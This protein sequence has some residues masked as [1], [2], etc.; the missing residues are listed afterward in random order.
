L[1]FSSSTICADGLRFLIFQHISSTFN[2]I[3]LSKTTSYEG[4]TF[5]S[6]YCSS[7]D[8][9]LK[10]L[11]EF[12]P[13]HVL[14]P[15]SSSFN[16]LKA[17]AYQCIYIPLHLASGANPIDVK[18]IAALQIRGHELLACIFRTPYISATPDLAF[19]CAIKI[20]LDVFI[21]LN[22]SQKV[23]HS[24]SS[25]LSAGTLSP[26]D[27][28]TFIQALVKSLSIAKD[29]IGS[30][31]DSNP[32][33]ISALPEI[34]ATLARTSTI[35]S[36]TLF[37]ELAG[38]LTQSC[39]Q[40]LVNTTDRIDKKHVS[41]CCKSFDKIL[42]ISS[43]SDVFGVRGCSL[44]LLKIVLHAC[45]QSGPS[46]AS[47]LSN[48]QTA[49]TGLHHVLLAE[50]ILIT[51]YKEG[52]ILAGVFCFHLLLL[53]N[54]CQLRDCCLRW[55]LMQEAHLQKF[56]HAQRTTTRFFYATP[57]NWWLLRKF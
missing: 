49:I 14:G 21:Q 4:H 56:S 3:V 12:S 53:T 27:R 6:Q 2:S 18:S 57:K 19:L 7:F 42:C 11:S 26:A 31:S 38:S 8:L 47:S 17:I 24:L 55:M 48:L 25:T 34:V 54:V 30:F 52:L 35:V 23:T 15:D 32:K 5:I 39:L 1:K 46:A 20:S 40:H 45:S 29:K 10:N 51:A 44:L 28:Q 13:A 50:D 9:F 22:Q 43:T 41:I 37:V 16:N 33:F 36:D